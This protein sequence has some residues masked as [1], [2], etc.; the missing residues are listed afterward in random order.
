MGKASDLSTTQRREAVVALLRREE[1][2]FKLAC[3]YNV[4]ENTL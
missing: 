3:R 4:S 1:P 2:A